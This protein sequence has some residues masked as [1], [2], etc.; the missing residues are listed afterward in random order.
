MKPAE[1]LAKGEVAGLL[2]ADVPGFA[3]A[4]GSGFVRVCV[5]ACVRALHSGCT[6]YLCAFFFLKEPVQANSFCGARVCFY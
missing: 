2:L 4:A 5:C 3:V 6:C 1:R